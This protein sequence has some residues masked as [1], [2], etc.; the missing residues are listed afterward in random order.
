[1]F[2]NFKTGFIG[3]KLLTLIELNDEL[4]NYNKSIKDFIP[5]M[6]RD[7]IYTTHFKF[8]LNNITYDFSFHQK[9]C[10]IKINNILILHSYK[11][12]TEF[13]TFGYI[14]KWN[15]NAPKA[16]LK[17]IKQDSKIIQSYINIIQQY[18]KNHNTI[19]KQKWIDEQEELNKIFK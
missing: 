6:K 5:N 13:L 19:K 12:L 18:I 11:G 9:L 3:G 4:E 16:L 14:Y 2:E 10:N 8:S 15:H 1:M 17:Q 7:K